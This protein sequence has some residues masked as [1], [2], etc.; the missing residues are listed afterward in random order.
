[1][2]FSGVEGDG[3]E[4]TMNRVVIPQA[5]KYKYSGLIVKEKGDI[6][7]DINHRIR[8]DGKNGGRLPECYVIRKFLQH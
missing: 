2:W 1:V 8:V 6:D 7:E 3:G 4:V 5:E